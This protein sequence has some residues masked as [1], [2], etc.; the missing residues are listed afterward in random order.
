MKSSE[1]HLTSSV[2]QGSALSSLLFALSIN[3]LADK[4]SCEILLFAGD[5]NI[6]IKINSVRDCVKLQKNLLELYQ[7]CIENKLQLYI[8]KCNVISFSRRSDTNA[9]AFI[10]KIGNTALNR[11]DR[12]K[13]LGVIFDD[14][15]S[16]QY[17]ITFIVNKTYRMLG[18]SSRSSSKFKKINTYRRLHYCFIRC[19]LEYASPVWNLYCIVQID[20]IERVQRKFTRIVA[21]EFN[22]PRET[23][24]IRLQKMNMIS[25]KNRR[26][27]LDQ[28]LFYKILNGLVYTSLQNEFIHH[29]TVHITRFATYCH[30]L[31]HI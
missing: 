12:V 11:T 18:F 5:V 22:L 21:F 14:K 25:L 27:V 13:D 2:P 3:D 9:I 16:F 4:I 23:Y 8:S 28:I 7:W 29:A 26:I 31:N 20:K 6:Y 1:I 15:L 17:H 10:Y 30:L 24:T 19:V